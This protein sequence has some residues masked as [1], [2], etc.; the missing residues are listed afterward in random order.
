ME[1]NHSEH[2]HH[3][4]EIT[5]INRAF[6]F[7]LSRARLNV[8]ANLA[9][10]GLFLTFFAVEIALALAELTALRAER[11]EFFG[12]LIEWNQFVQLGQFG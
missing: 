8:A 9:L 1:H 10:D 11:Y 3:N 12:V 2:H 7:E 5:N 6:I 4:P